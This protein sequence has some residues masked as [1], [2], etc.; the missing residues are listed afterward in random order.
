MVL[1]THAMIGAAVA[2]IFP[3]HPILGFFA[4]FG[5]H[6]LADAIPH[7]HYT[8]AT[9]KGDGGDPMKRDMLIN[10]H[11]PLDLF[12]ISIDAL[13]G[14]TCAVLLLG[15]ADPV[16]FS[17][18]LLGAAGGILPDGLQFL[19]WKWRHQPLTALQRFHLWVHAKSNLDDKPIF[20]P[21][22]QVALAL[23]CVLLVRL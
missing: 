11:F 17:A 4:A 1:A 20:G 22:L 14:I 9:T 2:N 8:L 6:F 10:K 18:T 16:I 7:W 15:A 19:Y 23:W 13:L 21:A 5:S 3:T 12:K